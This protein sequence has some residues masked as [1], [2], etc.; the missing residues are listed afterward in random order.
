MLQIKLNDITVCS[1]SVVVVPV[2]YYQVCVRMFAI[3]WAGGWV[4]E[5]S[6]KNILDNGSIEQYSRFFIVSAR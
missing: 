4:V 3:M 6:D 1:E 5:H 2:M